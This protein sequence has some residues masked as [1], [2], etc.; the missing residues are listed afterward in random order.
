M[1]ITYPVI[2]VF[3]ARGSGRLRYC[4]YARLTCSSSVCTFGGN[5]PYNLKSLLSSEGKAEPLLW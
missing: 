3:F 4:S 1:R 2:K 5:R